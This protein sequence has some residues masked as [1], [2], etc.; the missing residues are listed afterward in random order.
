MPTLEYVFSAHPQMLPCQKFS[1][2]TGSAESGRSSRWTLVFR[3]LRWLEQNN[4]LWRVLLVLTFPAVTDNC[5]GLRFLP[6]G[7][8]QRGRIIQ[9]PFDLFYFLPL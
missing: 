5:W 9:K 1:A 6:P 3:L 7:F 2:H 4:F 8:C